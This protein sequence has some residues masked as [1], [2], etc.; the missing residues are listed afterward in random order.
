MEL[1]A[2]MLVFPELSITGYEPLLAS[3]LATTQDDERFND[4]QLISNGS[5]VVIGLGAPIQAEAGVMIGMVIFQ[6]NKPRQTY[7]KQYLHADELPFFVPGDTPFFL[8]GDKDKI[9][10]AICYELFVPEHAV[11]AVANGANVYL[12]SVAKTVAGAAESDR[13]PGRYGEQAWVICA[14]VELCGAL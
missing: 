1:E 4:F 3:E 2:N 7:S 6:P 13:D 12:C 9:A 14:D 11:G 5:K 10:L 8:E